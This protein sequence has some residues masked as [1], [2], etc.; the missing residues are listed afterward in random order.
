MTQPWICPRCNVVNAPSVKKCDC[1]EKPMQRYA[2]LYEN[3]QGISHPVLRP[4]CEPASH[5]WDMA[6]YCTKCGYHKLAVPCVGG[7][8]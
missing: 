4:Q 2:Q 7:W 1:K 3:L 8:I 5:I 6:G